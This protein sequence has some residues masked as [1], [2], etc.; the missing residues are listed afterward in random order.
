MVTFERM[1]AAHDVIPT[2]AA[3]FEDSPKNL[4]PAHQLGMKT[5]LVGP[6]A[7]GNTDDFIDFRATSV[8]DF[9]QAA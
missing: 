4:R 2:R 1:M 8:K 7:A 3:F 9:L 6:K 5:V